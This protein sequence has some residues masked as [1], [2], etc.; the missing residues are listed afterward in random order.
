MLKTRYI[1]RGMCLEFGPVG[2]RVI[3]TSRIVEIRAIPAKQ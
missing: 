1:G 2:G 3:T